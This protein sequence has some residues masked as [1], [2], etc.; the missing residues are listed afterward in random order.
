MV[1]GS[2]LPWWLTVVSVIIV[3]VV[4]AIAVR[5]MWRVWEPEFRDQY[6]DAHGRQFLALFLTSFP[7]FVVAH[8]LFRRSQRPP[9]RE[10]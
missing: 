3:V 5:L 4:L 6:G 9:R 10:Q 2:G 7:A 1:T 8:L